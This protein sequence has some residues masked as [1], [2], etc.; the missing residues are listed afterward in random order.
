M[1]HFKEPASS[2]GQVMLFPPS[3]DELVPLESEVR[4]LDEAMDSMDWS[5]LE[6]SY[7]EIGRPAY[8][9]R[10]VAKALVYAYSKGI[11]SSRRIAEMVANDVRFIWLCEGDRPD[12]HTIARFR[13]DKFG[14]LGELFV[15]SVRLCARAGLVLLRSVSADGSKLRANVSRSSLYDEERLCKE[16]EAIERILREAEAVDAEEDQLYGDRDGC[17]LPEEMKDPVVRRQ[18]LAELAE[19]LRE[20][21][22]KTISESD[23]ECRM[24]MST[25]GVHPAYNVQAAVDAENQV[26]VAASVTNAERDHEQLPELLDQMEENTGLSAGVVLADAGYSSESTLT[27]LALRGQEALIP[28]CGD[29]KNQAVTSPFAADKFELNRKR[30]VL[31]CPAGRELGFRHEHRKGS[32]TYRRYA[33]TGCRSCRFHSE[34]VPSGRASRC[35]D[36]SVIAELRRDM[37]QKLNTPEGKALFAARKATVEPVFGR[38]KQNWGMRRLVLRGLNGAAA[39]VYLA[40]TAHNLMKWVAA[41]AADALSRIL[42][43]NTMTRA[44]CLTQ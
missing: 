23:P 31:V 3:L 26:I 34:C 40:A 20:Q 5:I 35:V 25:Q 17:E 42:Q 19:Q 15:E 28:A 41:Q 13:K 36:R 16:R 7:S 39:E 1:P 30:D 21:K 24:M 11:R 38:I 37:R 2:R 14:E 4:L 9:P 43:S 12:Y 44:H 32:G 27:E 10:A 18:K 33:A 29:H 6:S 22:R 8:H